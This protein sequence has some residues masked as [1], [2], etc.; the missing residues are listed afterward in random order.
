MFRSI[1]RRFKFDLG[2]IEVSQ[3]SYQRI[4]RAIK[5]VI[6]QDINQVINR[7]MNRIIDRDINGDMNRVINRIQVRWKGLIV[8]GGL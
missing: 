8:A 5:R 1:G 2:V 7:D 6:N 3:S 4:C